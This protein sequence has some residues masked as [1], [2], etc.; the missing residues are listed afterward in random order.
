MAQMTDVQNVTILFAAIVREQEAL[1]RGQRPDKANWFKMINGS[2]K[3]GLLFTGDDGWKALWSLT[4]SSMRI[5]KITHRADRQDVMGALAKVL[6]R[7]FV[8]ERLDVNERNV[9]RVL[10]ETTKAAMCTFKTQKPL[11]FRGVGVGRS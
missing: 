8:E 2:P 9:A 3:R 6:I 7:K 10:V 4:D 11:S 5:G 1:K